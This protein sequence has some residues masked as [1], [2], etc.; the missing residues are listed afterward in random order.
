MSGDEGTV[1][2]LGEYKNKPHGRDGLE[3][4]PNP[5]GANVVD[6]VCPEF[7]CLCPKTGQPDMATIR[8][9]YIPNERCVES[10][11]LKLYIWHFRER[12]VFH[13][14]VTKEIFDDL[15]HALK[16]HWLQVLGEFG[17]RGGIYEKV[18]CTTTLNSMD[19]EYRPFGT[20]SLAEK[21]SFTI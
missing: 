13:E 3:W 17:V 4:F 5:I 9:R 14:A 18:L 6:L 12:G 2:K 7:T 8:I 10:K 19:C 21:Y 11:S 20:D 1:T 15:V 16:P